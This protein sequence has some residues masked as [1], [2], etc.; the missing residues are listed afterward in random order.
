MAFDIIQIFKKSFVLLFVDPLLFG[1]A[2]IYAII[3]IAFSIYSSYNIHLTALDITSINVSNMYFILVYAVVIFLVSTFMSGMVFIR[4]VN[5]K[6]PINKIINKAVK[7]FSALIATT[8]L[9]GIIILAGLIAFIIPGIYLIFKLILAPVSSVVEEKSP[10]E[11]L[12]RS[13]SITF[14]NWW[15]LFALFVLLG[16]VVSILENLPYISYFFS[17]VLII[18]YPLVFIA[19]TKKPK[20]SRHT[21]Y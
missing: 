6:Q 3:S 19:L 5:K 9:T 14:G 7:R 21:Y 10:I 13:W 11:A 20:R 15:Y 18:S 8:F 1:L 2:L 4:I 16:I 17:F 12:K